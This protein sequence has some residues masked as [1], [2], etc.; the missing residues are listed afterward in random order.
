MYS[1]SEFN[2]IKIKTASP[3]VNLS[4]SNTKLC[5]AKQL[6]SFENVRATEKAFDWNPGRAAPAR[7]NIT[8]GA[9]LSAIKIWIDI[10]FYSAV[11]SSA[12]R[13]LFDYDNLHAECI[14]IKSTAGIS[15]A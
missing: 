2:L 14:E 13:A 11:S 6:I 1:E 9:L 12:V 3:N 15:R 5:S 8:N 4:A 10:V 7:M